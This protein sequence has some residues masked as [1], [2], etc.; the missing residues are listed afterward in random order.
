MFSFHYLQDAPIVD[1]GRYPELGGN[2]NGPTLIRTPDWFESPRAKY[3]L[4]FAHHFGRT[5]RL[6][7]ADDL[8]GPW[9]LSAQP[10]LEL[11]DSLFVTDRRKSGSTMIGARF[12]FIITAESKTAAN[13]PGEH[14]PA[15]A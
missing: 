3:L 4:Y 7:F 15:T 14:C 12:A 9:T 13:K 5:I 1:T 6:A 2:I 11:E 10:P 8:L